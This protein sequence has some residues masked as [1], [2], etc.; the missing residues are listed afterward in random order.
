VLQCNTRRV[1]PQVRPLT[2]DPPPATAAS[3]CSCRAA[4]G[5]LRPSLSGVRQ[6]DRPAF[7]TVRGTAART[8]CCGSTPPISPR[9]SDWPAT[10]TRPR[11][12][13]EVY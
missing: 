11:P 1:P 12:R 2:P 6:R 10:S 7:I 9:S 3:P 4:S 5:C 13:C 8:A